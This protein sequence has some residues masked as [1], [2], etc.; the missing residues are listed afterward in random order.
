M[1]K[2]INLQKIKWDLTDFYSFDFEK[3]Q[4]SDTDGLFYLNDIPFDESTKKDYTTDAQRGDPAETRLLKA[5]GLFKRGVSVGVLNT[6]CPTNPF[7]EAIGTCINFEETRGMMDSQCYYWFNIRVLDGVKKK[8]SLCGKKK[9]TIAEDDRFISGK[10]KRVPAFKIV[11]SKKMFKVKQQI[12]IQKC[13]KNV[14]TPNGN[15]IN[16]AKEEKICKKNKTKKSNRNQITNYFN[17]KN[18]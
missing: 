15:L 16:L 9:T 11:R 10:I 1:K 3:G 12:T 17:K 2:K 6:G 4:L 8:Y 14:R 5:I 13:F 18:V 7:I